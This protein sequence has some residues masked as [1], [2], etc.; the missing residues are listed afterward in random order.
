MSYELVL[1][2]MPPDISD[3]VE[4]I[5]GL[6]DSFCHD[7][8]ECFPSW[9]DEEDGGEEED[10]DEQPRCG[11]F[12]DG[13][14][15]GD[16]YRFS[17]CLWRDRYGLPLPDHPINRP[18]DEARRVS[19]IDL[20]FLRLSPTGLLTPA[21]GIYFMAGKARCYSNTIAQFK[22]YEN[23][24]AEYPNHLAFPMACHS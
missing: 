6:M 19:D 11:H 20:R 15:V 14:K 3:P 2:I 7:Y 12:W 5:L 16:H 21:G 17:G 9:E 24:L 10:D 23:R 13:A 18:E 8:D 22:A 1:A 4:R